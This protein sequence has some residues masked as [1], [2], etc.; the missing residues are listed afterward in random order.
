MLQIKIFPIR[1]YTERKTAKCRTHTIAFCLGRFEPSRVPLPFRSG[2]A[3]IW[4]RHC[5][6]HLAGAGTIPVDKYLAYVSYQV[7]NVQFSFQ[8]AEEVMDTKLVRKL[9]LRRSSVKEAL[10]NCLVLAPPPTSQG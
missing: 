8:M 4:N 2:G 6:H 9:A 7:T 10:R 5:G 1:A 3:L